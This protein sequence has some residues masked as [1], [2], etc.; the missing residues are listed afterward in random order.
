MPYAATSFSLTPDQPSSS[1]CM[2][3]NTDGR[4]GPT[5]G[6]STCRLDTSRWLDKL[7]DWGNLCGARR[8]ATSGT[9]R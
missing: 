1:S 3:L 7:S 5:S 9:A 6:R 4:R 2:R 8:C